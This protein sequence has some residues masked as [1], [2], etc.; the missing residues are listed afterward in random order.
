MP[1][2]EKRSRSSAH[3]KY[4]SPNVREEEIDSEKAKEYL[5]LNRPGNRHIVKRNVDYLTREMLSHRFV[6]LNGDTIRF[7][8]DGKLA[9]GQH[10]LQA[11][12]LSGK[13]YRFLVVRGVTEEAFPT[14]DGGRKRQVSDWLSMPDS[15]FYVPHYHV[16]V[17]SALRW[18]LL[19]D[20]YQSFLSKEVT[21]TT[22]RL[23]SLK[24]YPGLP[25][26]VIA[27]AGGK[28]GLRMSPAMLGACHF[29]L[30]RQ[31]K[32]AA[33]E[34]MR[35]LVDGLE[36]KAGDPQY[37]VRQWIIKNR[38]G[39]PSSRFSQYAG[40]LI[41]RAWNLWRRGEKIANVKAPET[42]PDTLEK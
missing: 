31:N 10:R 42:K 7:T 14:I 1:T 11:V 15:P 35:S 36:L 39:E 41:L 33:E 18:V 28:A 21:T 40:H 24:K 13:T 25:A 2:K 6:A 19:W 30:A 16:A 20:K 5:A 37:T 27:Y 22:E 3:V 17:A 38:T 9:D 4:L 29:I 32:D 12:I 26:H 8:S 23:E 34:F